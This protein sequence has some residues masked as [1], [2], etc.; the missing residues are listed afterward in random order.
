MISRVTQQALIVIDYLSHLYAT[1]PY[2]PIK[3]LQ[4]NFHSDEEDFAAA[5]SWIAINIRL[6]QWASEGASFACS[7]RCAVLDISIKSLIIES[8]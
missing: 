3:K 8:A 4:G 5:K 1:K 7:Q 2:K 6:K